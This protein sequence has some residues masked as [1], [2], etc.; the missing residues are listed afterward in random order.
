M[1]VLPEVTK[2]LLII[3][4]LMFLATLSFENFMYGNL[5]LFPV[6]SPDFQPYQVVTHMFMHGDGMHIFFNMFTL[7]MFGPDIERAFGPKKFLIYYLG[8]GLGAAALHTLVQYI[9]ISQLDP[10]TM[11]YMQHLFTPTVGASGAIF[12]LL[13]AFGMLY[14]NRMIMLLIPPIPMKAKYFVLI[15]GAIELYLGV[16]GKQPGVAHFA[17][18]GGA[19]FGVLMVLFWRKRGER[20]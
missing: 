6:Q 8:T 16:S 1:Q 15:F 10:N 2:N 19:I 14:P 18:L 9:E 17:H 11:A 3:N 12:G 20:F 4:V 13:A 7:F 5:S